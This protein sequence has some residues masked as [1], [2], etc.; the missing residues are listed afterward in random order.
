[1]TSP[2]NAT[3]HQP[4][5]PDA[6]GAMGTTSTGTTTG[7]STPPTTAPQPDR[8]HGETWRAGWRRWRVPLMIIAIILAGG[9]LVALIGQFSQSR[10]NSYLDPASSFEDGSHALSDILGERGFTVTPAYSPA[11]AIAA[12]RRAAGGPSAAR[13]VTLVVTS[14]GL[15]S[16]DHA[17]ALRRTGADLILVA[18][19]PKALAALAPAVTVASPGPGPNAP[20]SSLPPRCTLPAARLAGPAQTDGITYKAPP[21]A[22]RCYPVTGRPGYSVVSYTAAGGRN[23]TV[24]GSA[25][26]L[27]NGLLAAEGNAALAL[28]LLRQHRDIVW[29]VPQPVRQLRPPA[30]PRAGRRHGPPLVPWQADLV[31]IQLALAALLAAVWRSRRPGPLIAEQLP[32]VVRASE[33]VEGHGR[34]YQSR[35][36][37]TRA[38]AALRAEL[39]SRLLPALGLSADAPPQA[40]A[41]DLAARTRLNA[42]EITAIVFGPAPETD[43]D[44]VRLARSL[45]E[46]DREVRAQ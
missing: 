40:V 41:E 18:P 12:V 1:M 24:I 45:D 43:D 3:A 16:S 6:H 29:L 11:S 10:T 2:A 28:N 38:A 8:L 27:I 34:L 21:S 19:G 30:L 26:P 39:L 37:R 42:A 46:L 44:L 31:I 25:T 36:A 9:L 14:P 22:A 4:A 17:A 7:T 33:T 23:I 32:V 35:R 20:L 5:P 15:I 13:Q